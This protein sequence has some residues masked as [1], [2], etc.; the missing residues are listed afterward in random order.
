M[1]DW[2]H[3]IIGKKLNDESLEFYSGHFGAGDHS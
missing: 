2:H 3:K 1:G